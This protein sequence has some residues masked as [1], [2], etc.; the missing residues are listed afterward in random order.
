[1]KDVRPKFVHVK[2]I[3]FSALVPLD[4][5]ENGLRELIESLYGKVQIRIV[6]MRRGVYTSRGHGS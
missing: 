4:S 3:G 2:G 1:M 6:D 5:Y